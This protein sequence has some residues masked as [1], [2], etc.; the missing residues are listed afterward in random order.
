MSRKPERSLLGTNFTPVG[1]LQP[2]GS[3]FDPMYMYAKLKTGI[4]NNCRNKKC[5]FPLFSVVF[6]V[7]PAFIWK[8]GHL[9]V[10]NGWDL[11]SGKFSGHSALRLVAEG[12]EGD[13][14]HGNNKGSL[15]RGRFLTT[16]IC[17]LRLNLGH[18]PRGELIILREC[19]P[20]RSPSRS[21]HCL[22]FRK[23]EGW[24]EGLRPLGI[25]LLRGDKFHP[26]GPTSPLGS[27]FS[28]RGKIKTWPLKFY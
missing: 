22:M 20:L 6:V 4:R 2:C 28:P 24:E 1:Q 26:W 19:S 21:E 27:H 7:P 12:Q 25:T 3:H 13:H 9:K 14:A 23:M 15:N 16:W 18:H 8:S 10:E 11:V 17:P 5:H